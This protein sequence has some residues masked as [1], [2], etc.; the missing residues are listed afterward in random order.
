MPYATNLHDGVR[1]YFEVKGETG[2]IIVMQYGFM[3]YIDAWR[4]AGYV[5]LL[6]DDYRLA[7]IDPR[8]M[9]QSDRP[10][11][12]EQY[13]SERMA[14]DIIAVLD[15]L[16]AKSGHFWGYSR[17]G[18]IGYELATWSDSRIQS[19]IIGAMHPYRREPETFAEQIELFSMGWDRSIPHF[20]AQNGP[21]DANARDQLLRNDS[22]ALAAASIAAQRDP[23]PAESLEKFDVPV[24]I[25]AGGEDKDFFTLA[26]EAAADIP[27]ARF[28][29]LPGLDHDETFWR[30][31]L[32]API[33]RS[34][35]R[36][37]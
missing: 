15:S 27:S 35:L 9:E 2:P 34:F 1:I 16:D 7:L 22:Q 4:E 5:D 26:K 36:E 12:P 19:V 31:D 24:L 21:L 28:V 32:V 29:E 10:H 30:S 17:G 37:M 8:G 20:E 14:S 23:G 3:G 6:A 13:A 25:Y 11:E 18:R 33:V